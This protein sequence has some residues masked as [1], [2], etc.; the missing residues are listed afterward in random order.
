M[1]KPFALFTPISVHHSLRK[2]VEEQLARMEFLNVIFRV[3]KPIPWC[4]AMVIVP[5]RQ[6]RLSTTKLKNMCFE[7][8]SPSAKN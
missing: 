1:L 5:K 7:E 2:K 3:D 4:A 8:S 6:C